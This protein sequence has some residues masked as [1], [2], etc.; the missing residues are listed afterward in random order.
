M[1]ADSQGR[2]ELIAEAKGVIGAPSFGKH[3]LECLVVQF[4]MPEMLVELRYIRMLNTIKAASRGPW[5]L[6][7]SSMR[8]LEELPLY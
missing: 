3:L 1:L 8:S 6:A 2:P 5:F 7:G 4:N